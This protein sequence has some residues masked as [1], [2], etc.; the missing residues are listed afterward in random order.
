MRT[1]T[2]R[3]R[4]S[5]ARLRITLL[6][7][8]ATA[9][10]SPERALRLLFFVVL[11]LGQKRRVALDV[12]A[13]RSAYAAMARLRISEA[14]RAT[15]EERNRPPGRCMTSRR[16]CVRQAKHER[17]VPLSG[18]AQ[19][20]RPSEQSTRRRHRRG[21]TAVSPLPRTNAS[22]RSRTD[23]AHRRRLALDQAFAPTCPWPTSLNRYPSL[24]L[25]RFCALP[26]GCQR[27]QHS[28]ARA[29]RRR[30]C[31]NSFHWRPTT[32]AASP[33]A[34]SGTVSVYRHEGTVSVMG[35]DP[36]CYPSRAVAHPSN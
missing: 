31:A 11:L 19:A 12:R 7:S 6:L 33:E 17:L 9:A 22:A 23:R 5:S 35:G 14:E 28:R 30:G 15:L 18:G 32:V 25:S 13:L 10:S 24:S 21:E 3:S 20:L 8:R 4:C 27:A 34:T 29:R 36:V 1:G 26:D 2:S 16:T